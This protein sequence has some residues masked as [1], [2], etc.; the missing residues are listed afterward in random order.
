MRESPP[1]LQPLPPALPPAYAPG[2]YLERDPA[3]AGLPIREPIA[4]PPSP[5]SPEDRARAA[6]LERELEIARSTKISVGFRYDFLDSVSDVDADEFAIWRFPLFLEVP[7]PADAKLRVTGEPTVVDNGLITDTGVA[8]EIALLGIQLGTEIVQASL[9]A[10][11]T[12]AG[13][14][15]GPEVTGFGRL[16]LAISSNL[17]LTP[18]FERKPVIESLL[19]YRGNTREG[20]FFGQVMQDRFGGSVGFRTPQDI[21]GVFEVA[22]AMLEGKRVEDNDKL[23]A[24]FSIGRDFALGRE[25]TLRPGAQAYFAHY[26]KDLSEAYP[27]GLDP[28]LFPEDEFPRGGGY[29]SPDSFLEAALR[30]DLTGPFLPETLPGSTFHLGGRV[31][32]QW[33]SGIDT[34]RFESSEGSR[35][36]FG[37]DAGVQVPMGDMVV[38]STGV[39]FLSSSPYDRV[40]FEMALLFPL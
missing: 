12:P 22:Y 37:G 13:F 11:I 2:L 7:A 35:A 18:F 15:E 16:T 27:L 26:D 24:F 17:S 3:G 19:S 38:F 36:T 9:G 31:G 33:V 39:G 30:L 1:N 28:E 5:L 29:F 8:A 14:K 32:A 40:Y 23:D 21:N 6:A 4:P 25:Y 10:G 20:L 34:P